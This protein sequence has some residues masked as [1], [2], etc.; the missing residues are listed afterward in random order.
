MLSL[1]PITSA[2]LYTVGTGSST[3]TTSRFVPVYCSLGSTTS[4]QSVS[5]FPLKS[6]ARTKEEALPENLN[7]RT[8]RDDGEERGIAGIHVPRQ[9]YIA[10]A[11]AELLNAVLGLFDSD[12]DKEDFERFARYHEF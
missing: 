7:R 3:T 1:K 12:Q 11:K 5:V 8:E 9:R 4:S 2:R 10:V 6:E